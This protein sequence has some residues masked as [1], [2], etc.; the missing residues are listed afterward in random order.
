MF[1][2]W[3]LSNFDEHVS[4]DKLWARAQD[5]K[6]NLCV[7]AVALNQYRSRKF[8]GQE[9]SLLTVSTHNVELPRA[10]ALQP[11]G[12]KYIV[13]TPWRAGMPTILSWD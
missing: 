13:L 9:N 5:H 2:L 4:H 10:A 8:V 3:D 6:F 7:V 12:Y 11:R 1:V